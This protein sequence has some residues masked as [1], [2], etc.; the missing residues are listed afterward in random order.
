VGINDVDP[1]LFGYLLE[2]WDLCVNACL[3]N[4]KTSISTDN[5]GEAN[6][7]VRM[8][9]EGLELGDQCLVIRN[10]LILECPIL[11]FG[12]VCAEHDRD[13]RGIK[14]QCIGQNLLLL[15]GMIAVIQKRST[16]LSEILNLPVG[17][18]H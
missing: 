7:D 4:A 17:S 14:C 12:I 6:E 8:R 5:R 9:W 1:L 13:D 10:E 11:G 3:D 18:Q 2:H 15:I 16:A